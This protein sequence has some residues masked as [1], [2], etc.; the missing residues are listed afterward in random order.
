VGMTITKLKT[1]TVPTADQNQSYEFFTKLGFAVAQ[2]LTMGPMRWLEVKPE[3]SSTTFVLMQGGMGNMKPGG[4]QGVQLLSTKIDEDCATLREAG[5]TV[6]GPHDRP[7]GRDASFSDPDGN[8]FV[9]MSV[10]S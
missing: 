8:G 4:L 10:D 5:V 9:L 3:E 1:V 7:W 6:D 2:D